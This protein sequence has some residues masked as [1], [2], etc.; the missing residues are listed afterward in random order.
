MAGDD[1]ACGINPVSAPAEVFSH[2]GLWAKYFT[3]TARCVH[4][5]SFGALG[6]YQSINHIEIEIFGI[7]R[8]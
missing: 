6:A 2:I 8:T 1:Y 7:H 5:M 3:S 4:L